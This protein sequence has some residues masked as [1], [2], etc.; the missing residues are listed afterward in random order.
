[1]G[2]LGAAQNTAGGAAEIEQLQ[3]KRDGSDVTIQV[4][5]TG[6]VKPTV[7]TAINPDRLVLILPGTI[8]DAKQK[9]FPLDANGVRA[10]RL[11]LN[12]ANPPVTR[13][14]VDLDSAHPYTLSSDGK[15]ITLRVQPS[16]NAEVVVRHVGPAPAAS[17]PLLG[18]FRRKPQPPATDSTTAQ[19]PIPVPP[20]FPPINFPEKQ[21]AVSTQTTANAS[22]TPSAARPK[23]GSLQQ[24]TVFPGMGTPGAGSVPTAQTATVSAAAAA[25]KPN[26]E[27]AAKTVPTSPAPASGVAPSSMSVSVAPVQPAPSAIAK[28]ETPTAVAPVVNKTAASADAVPKVAPAPASAAATSTTPSSAGSPNITA[29]VLSA[30]VSSPEPAAATA[31]NSVGQSAPASAG[32]SAAKVTPPST[33]ASNDAKASSVAPAAALTSASD[34]KTTSASQTA[35]AAKASETAG[36]ATTPTPTTQTA[37]AAS[38][39]VATQAAGPPPP[40]TPVIQGASVS[41]PL[42]LAPGEKAELAIEETDAVTPEPE[43]TSQKGQEVPLI[44]VADQNLMIGKPG[45]PDIP[46]ALALRATHPDFRTAFKVKYVA[47]GTAYIDGGRSAGL[48]EGM[49]LVVRDTP[50]GS[51]IAAAD[52]N[53][54]DVVAELE[55]TSVAETSS[56]SDVRTPKRDLKAGDLAYLSSHDEQALVNQSTL[57]ATRKYPTVISF[58]ESD[59]LDEEA[60]VQVPRPPMPS[61]NRARGRIGVDYMGTAF[62]GS[63]G[64]S[65]TDLGL[66]AR[67]DMTRIGGTYWNASGYWRGRLTANN[68]SGNSTLQDLINRTYHLSMTYDNPNSPW[69]AGFGRMYLPWATSLDTIDGGYFGRRLGH[70]ATLGVFG[71]S[72]PDP[73]SWSYSPNRRIGGVFVNFEGGSYDSFR[74]TSTSGMALSTLQWKIDRPFV[75]F[76]NGIYYK[77]YVA[78]YDSLQADSPVGY[79]AGSSPGAGIARHFLTVRYQPHERIEFDGNY[80]YL[81]DL[82]TFD[83]TLVGTSLLDKYLF[84][85]FSGGVRL[86]VIKTVWVYTNLG[87]SN[88]TGD[89]SNSL[90]ELYGLTFDRLP[91]VHIRADGHYARFNSS[92]GNGSYSSVSLSRSMGDNF[93][94]ELLGGQQN[95]VSPLSSNTNAKFLTSNV[96]MNMGAHYFIQGGFTLNRG[97]TQSYDQWLFSI[98]YRFDS[99][100]AKAE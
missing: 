74:Y 55:V 51:V 7:E 73:T 34:V 68:Y 1:M 14:V 86:E 100:R 6:T 98:G 52:G 70:S 76:E 79:T 66:V 91:W 47:A 11:G 94:L 31:A 99:R 10:V 16:E 19:A 88:R 95:F 21:A 24:G 82:P 84:Q 29:K 20:K 85:G 53:P 81:R 57:S 50:T 83:P 12:S 97:V 30:T 44:T 43:A 22:A 9:H 26:S 42:G 78:I 59:T 28:G 87:K 39:P 2:S 27:L 13:V 60:R 61:V 65:N 40:P 17:A 96:E 32:E 5:L 77:R 75:F 71:G 67:L 54:D 46:A 36:T 15:S 56:V 18:V 80:T 41:N 89:T 38:A 92:F 58:T 23:T 45:E 4:V 3:V 90:N 25:A 37:A 69:V 93:R 49:K 8:S 33:Q 72:T 63:S 64:G 48:A 35:T 62:H